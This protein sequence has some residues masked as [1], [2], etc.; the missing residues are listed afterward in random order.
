MRRGSHPHRLRG[1]RDDVAGGVDLR[2]LR[3]GAWVLR[4]GASVAFRHLPGS[5]KGRL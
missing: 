5:E 3:H 1:V 4:H 2:V